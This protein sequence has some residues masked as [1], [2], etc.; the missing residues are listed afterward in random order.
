[1]KTLTAFL[2]G[3]ATVVGPIAV[4]FGSAVMMASGPRPSPPPTRLEQHLADPAPAAPA[5]TAMTAVPAAQTAN[6]GDQASVDPTPSVTPAGAAQST[7]SPATSVQQP[8]QPAAQ[9][10]PGLA[11]QFHSDFQNRYPQNSL[12]R[13][14]D[15][16]ISRYIQK[17]NRRWA[18]H[19]LHDFDAG[20]PSAGEIQ[21]SQR[22][23]PLPSS[24]QPS[25][26]AASQSNAA[27]AQPTTPGASADRRPQNPVSVATDDEAR[28]YIQKRYRRWARHHYRDDEEG[29]PAVVETRQAPR[30]VQPFGDRIV[31]HSRPFFNFGH[32]DED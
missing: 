3:V 15:E 31:V 32:D 19:H 12:A 18:K 30:D 13:A 14:A 27:V 10:Q 25:T 6:S 24:S 16:D 7:T 20:D 1:M 5:Q 2:A 21:Q 28:R 11:A 23:S 4:G 8:S 17:R 9:P 22:E 26:Q 29:N